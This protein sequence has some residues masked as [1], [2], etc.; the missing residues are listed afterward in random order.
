MR[1]DKKSVDSSE[2]V[3]QVAVML[4]HG[5]IPA[6]DVARKMGVSLTTVARWAEGGKI[7]C[8]TVSHRVF[9]KLTTLVEHIGQKQ[10]VIF[11]FVKSEKTDTKVSRR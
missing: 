2:P 8:E 7:E 9:V 4:R 10:A 11:G 5:Y 6:V 1:R 3:D